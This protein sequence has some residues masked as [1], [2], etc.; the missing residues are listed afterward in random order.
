MSRPTRVVSVGTG[1]GS[2]SERVVA[3]GAALGSVGK[4]PVIAQA[5]SSEA[6]K[7]MAAHS[8]E[9]VFVLLHSIE[10]GAKFAA[11]LNGRPESTVGRRKT[12]RSRQT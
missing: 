7:K 5:G 1:R 4:A 10:A 8:A 9:T 12:S 3:E 6:G 2:P 11:D